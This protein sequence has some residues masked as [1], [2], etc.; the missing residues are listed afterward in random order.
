MQ[1]VVFYSLIRLISLRFIYFS[2]IC[3]HIS[4]QSYDTMILHL[5]FY[6]LFFAC[7]L[8]AEVEEHNI[9]PTTSSVLRK[10]RE[11]P[12]IFW[13]LFALVVFDRRY[14]PVRGQEA[15]VCSHAGR[16]PSSDTS[17]LRTL[18]ELL[19]CQCPSVLFKGGHQEHLSH[20]LCMRM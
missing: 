3:K 9:L 13:F 6:V 17:Q 18:Y 19:M 15:R 5:Y 4:F 2:Q 10:V 12:L 16:R 1:G 14:C 20:R 8:F 7:L 11:V